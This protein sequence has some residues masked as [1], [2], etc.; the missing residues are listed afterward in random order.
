MNEVTV[1][2]AENKTWY[3]QPKRKQN[4]EDKEWE[5]KRANGERASED[6]ETAQKAWD[7]AKEL[8]ENHGTYSNPATAKKKL[9]K[10]GKFQTAKTKTYPKDEDDV[11]SRRF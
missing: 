8:A 9:K 5:V 10:N 2:V 1:I 4:S 11:D 3:A 7:R 6:F